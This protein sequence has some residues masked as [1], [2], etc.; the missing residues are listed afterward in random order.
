MSQML[1]VCRVHT[2]VQKRGLVRTVMTVL[3]P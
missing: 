1:Q 2:S 3:G